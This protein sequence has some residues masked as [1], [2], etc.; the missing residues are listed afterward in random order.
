MVQQ[1][2]VVV[3]SE[4]QRAD[5]RLPSCVSKSAHHAVGACAVLDFC[6]PV[7]SPERRAASRRLAIM[8]SRRRASRCQ[9]MPRVRGSGRGREPEG[10]RLEESARRSP[11]APPASGADRSTSASSASR[12]DRTR[13]KRPGVSGQL[14]ARGSRRD[15]G[16]AA[17]RRKRARRRGHHDLAIEH[18]FLGSQRAHL[19][20]HVGK[21]ACQRLAGLGLKVDVVAVAKCQAAEAVPLRLVL[22]L[23]S[24]RE[25]RR[26]TRLPSAANGGWSLVV[27][28]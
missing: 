3:E 21:V 4:Q 23:R 5:D 22:P 27:T 11:P 6:M 9:P 15:E 28:Q 13:S 7:R 19:L 18:E 16:A 14:V 20:D 25:S 8:P 17:A 1:P 2:V 26:P 12:A 24:R 10:R